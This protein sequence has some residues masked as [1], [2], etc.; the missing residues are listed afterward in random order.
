MEKC[1]LVQHK[2]YWEQ[3]R[4]AEGRRTSGFGLASPARGGRTV[5]GAADQEGCSEE[6]SLT[7]EGWMAV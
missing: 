4:A 2:P 1:L 3:G 5:Q 7:E 6:S